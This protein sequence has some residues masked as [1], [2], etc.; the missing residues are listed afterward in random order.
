MLLE[1][2]I[3]NKDDINEAINKLREIRELIEQLNKIQIHVGDTVKV[4]HTGKMYTTNTNFFADE[5]IKNKHNDDVI[6]QLAS[7]ASRYDFAKS[8]FL[9]D[10][11]SSL[12]DIRFRV[13]YISEDKKAVISIVED[14]MLGKYSKTYIISI[15]GLERW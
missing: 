12:D 5:I 13:E 15:D 8:W 2:N 9:N 3:H 1:V 11:V 14:Y 7:L 6:E 10:N 4:T